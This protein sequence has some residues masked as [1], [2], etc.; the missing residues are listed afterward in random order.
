MKA[1]WSKWSKDTYG[2]IF[3]QLA[4]REDIVRV[5]EMLFEDEPTMEN[6]IVLKNAQAELKMYLSL[7]EH[8]WK[9]KA[10]MTWFTEEDRNTRFFHNH[11]NEK[12]QKLQ[13]KRIQDN[14]G[15]WF[16]DQ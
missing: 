15:S 16:E 9:Q 3:K 13:P 10:G 14:N 8:Y 12:R 4:I 11:V 2:D 7:E 5:K 1:A 6:R